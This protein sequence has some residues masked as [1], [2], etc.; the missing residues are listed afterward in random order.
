VQ[1][2][3]KKSIGVF[4]SGFGGLAILKEIKKELPEYDY[5]YLGD[6]ARAPY[7][8]RAKEEIYTFTEEGV[9]FLFEQGAEL[10]VLA[11]NSSSSDALRK[12]QQEYIP[13][14]FPSKKVLGVLIPAAEEAIEKTRNKKVGLIATEATITSSSFRRELKKLDREVKIFERACPELVPLVETGDTDSEK[15]KEVLN[16]YLEPLKEGEIDTLIL[17]C[18]HYEFLEKNIK[19]I[20]GE[21]VLVISE[22]A[23]ISDKLK[24]YLDKHTEIKDKLSRDGERVF[25]TTGF[26]EKFD[27]Q[28]G[29]FFGEKIES[30]EI[31]IS[32]KIS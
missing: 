17:G 22:G 32:S 8:S 19:E 13:Q 23:V 3:S 30:Q 29:I 25:F 1:N 11:C 27:S 2:I 10:V 31:A 15:T 28:G 16:V 24:K 12:L 21:G 20:M 14:K 5:L 18:T 6:T 9:R 4:D 26:K 7:G